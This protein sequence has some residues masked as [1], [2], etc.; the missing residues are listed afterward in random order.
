M[1]NNTIRYDW[2]FLDTLQYS[3]HDHLNACPILSIQMASNSEFVCSRN[4]LLLTM[5]ATKVVLEHCILNL[6]TRFD[7]YLEFMI[8][9]F[10]H[11]NS[12]ESLVHSNSMHRIV[13]DLFQ[14]LNGSRTKESSMKLITCCLCVLSS[15]LVEENNFVLQMAAKDQHGNFGQNLVRLMNVYAYPIEKHS[16]HK[17]YLSHCLQML[18]NCFDRRD[19]QRVFYCN[20]LKV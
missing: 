18:R 7:Q 17:L 10:I 8:N 15:L 16:Q 9:V 6:D 20:D 12:H 2:H 3:I 19:T 13:R 4:Q 5:N 11:V 14:M 1:T